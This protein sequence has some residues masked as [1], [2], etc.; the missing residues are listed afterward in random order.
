LRV[1]SA[2]RFEERVLPALERLLD[3]PF[4]HV[5]ISHGAPVHSR[6]D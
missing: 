6:A 1:W 3:L 4:E 2:P 5:I